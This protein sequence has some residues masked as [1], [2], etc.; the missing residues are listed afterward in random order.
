MLSHVQEYAVALDTTVELY[1]LQQFV[2]MYGGGWST[3]VAFLFHQ[4]HAD[5]TGVLYKERLVLYW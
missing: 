3:C 5:C 2:C 1:T 4:H